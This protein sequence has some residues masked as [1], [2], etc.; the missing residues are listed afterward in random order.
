VTV[1]RWAA[2]PPEKV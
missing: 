2:V 1:L